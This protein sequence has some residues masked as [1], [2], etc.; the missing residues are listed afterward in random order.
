MEWKCKKIKELENT[1]IK[2]GFSFRDTIVIG[3][4]EGK[5]YKI[6]YENVNL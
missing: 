6:N 2:S 5:I 3:D 4:D 1:T